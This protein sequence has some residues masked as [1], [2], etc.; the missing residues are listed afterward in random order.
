MKKRFARKRYLMA[1]A[2]LAGS[3]FVAMERPLVPFIYSF[4]GARYTRSGPQGCLA[5]ALKLFDWL[6]SANQMKILSARG[7]KATPFLMQSILG[8]QTL[9]K[10]INIVF[11]INKCNFP[12]RFML[13]RKREDY[14]FPVCD[15]PIVF[16]SVPQTFKWAI[17]VLI[18]SWNLGKMDRLLVQR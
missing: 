4:S 10:D 9:T 12:V 11:I 14:M 18:S 1:V 6:P 13:V 16:A 5:V 3:W 15:A 2:K 8:K 17:S 7:D